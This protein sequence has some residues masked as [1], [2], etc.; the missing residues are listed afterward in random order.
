MVLTSYRVLSPAIRVCLTPSL[1]DNSAN[2][3]PTSRRQAH[4]SW[5]SASAPFV[6]GASASTASRPTYRDDREPPPWTEQDGISIIRKSEL[7]K[8]N[9]AIRNLPSAR[10]HHRGADRN[11]LVQVGDILVQHP[12]AAIGDEAPDRARHVGAMD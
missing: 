5:P 12:D 11:P 8:L 10:H 9:L 2:L 1:A 3:T 7:V 4:T 6:K